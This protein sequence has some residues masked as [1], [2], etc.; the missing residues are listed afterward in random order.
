MNILRA[1]PMDP[2]RPVAELPARRV[3]RSPKGEWIVD[4][5]QVLAGRA[6]VLLNTRRDNP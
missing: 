5:G 2:I 3:F 6:R 1:Q 4:F